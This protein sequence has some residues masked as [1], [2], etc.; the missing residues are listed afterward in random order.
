[1]IFIRLKELNI[2]CEDCVILPRK[3]SSLALLLSTCIIG[4]L[5]ISFELQYLSTRNESMVLEAVV[6]ATFLFFFACST[7]LQKIDMAGDGPCLSE[8]SLVQSGESQVE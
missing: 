7:A 1:M 5:K 3:P 4:I 2:V 6:Q 8:V